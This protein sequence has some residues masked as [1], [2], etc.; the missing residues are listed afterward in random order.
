MYK[1]CADAQGTIGLQNINR[2]WGKAYLISAN[3]QSMQTTG[4]VGSKA[5]GNEQMAYQA[6]QTA[7]D[8]LANSL[9]NKQTLDQFFN[10]M[11]ANRQ[12]KMLGDGTTVGTDQNGAWATGMVDRGDASNL[13]FNPAQIPSGVTPTSVQRG[14]KLFIARI[15]S[16]AGERQ[17]VLFHHFPSE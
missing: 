17:R 6:A 16:D 1:D 4:Q 15:Q 11:S 3:L 13:T 8:Q 9:K 14:N 2:V 7:N 12:A 10:Q 5:P